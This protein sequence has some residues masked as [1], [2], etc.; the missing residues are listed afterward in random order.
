MHFRIATDDNRVAIS[1]AQVVASKLEE[2]GH[3]SELVEIA[4]GRAS[5][6]VSYF[7]GYEKITLRKL[8]DALL[9]S[10]ADI[11]VYAMKDVI[12]NYNTIS[13]FTFP[14]FLKREN[15]REVVITRKGDDFLTLEPGT[16]IGVSSVRKGAQIKLAFPYM[17][18]E[19]FNGT[20]AS[21]LEKLDKKQVD[22]VVL[23]QL[24]TDL[25]NL[26]DRVGVVLESDVIM[27]AFGQGMIGIQCK[28]EAK[29]I[30]EEIQKLNDKPTQE[31][32]EV[33]QSI[34]ESLECKS[35][36]PVAGYCEHSLGGSLR[37][38]AMISS[39]NGDKVFRSRCKEKGISP[40]AL[41]K[42]VAEDLLSQGAKELIK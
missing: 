23:S 20:V 21:K 12:Y 11:A 28:K 34:L 37:V 32:F 6:L 19:Y 31:C 35:Q 17:E 22:A 16:K 38:V 26:G 1:Q 24:D 39:K 33:E 10:K 30:I 15:H 5:K 9:K 42:R 13:G 36:S 3:T 18:P 41:G 25:L 40:K 8:Q 29:E 4:T 7:Y 2:L 14:A 27:P